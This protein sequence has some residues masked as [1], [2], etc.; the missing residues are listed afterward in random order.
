MHQDRLEQVFHQFVTPRALPYEEAERAL[1]ARA[2]R[3]TPVPGIVAWRWRPAQPN[4]RRLL[5]VHGWESRAAHWGAFIAPLL[6]AGYEVLAHDGPAHGD[7]AGSQTHILAWGQA[8]AAVAAALGPLDALL[9]HSLGSAA[10]LYAFAHGVQVRTSVHLCG[11]SSVRRVLERVAQAAALGPEQTARFAQRFER[12]MGAPMAVMDLAQLQHGLRH[13]ALLL[14]DPLDR[15][16]PF[17][18][19]AMLAAAW[20]GARLEKVEGVGHR[21]ILRDPAVIAASL[22]WLSCC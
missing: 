13:P 3:L 7:S 4:G 6:D 21:R 2:E 15:E 5:L 20:P 17:A 1:L 19:S 10:A 8:L 9:G 12:H 11:P 14:H 18:E 22:A 16:V